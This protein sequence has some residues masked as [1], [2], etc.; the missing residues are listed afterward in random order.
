MGE[1]RGRQVWPA[2]CEILADERQ[3]I[4]VHDDRR[5]GSGLLCDRV[6]KGLVE[7]AVPFPR[8]V[9]DPVE[10][11]AARMVE[12]AVVQEPQR[13]VRDHLGGCPPDLGRD[14]NHA[15]LQRVLSGRHCAARSVEPIRLGAGRGDPER[16]PARDHRVFGERAAQARCH[17]ARCRSKLEGS[18]GAAHERERSPVRDDDEAE[19]GHETLSPARRRATSSTSRA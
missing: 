13:A 15:Q 12:Q 7:L 3:V 18:P 10:T 8:L 6:S 5:P 9:P 2:L 19:P 11:R 17:A 1:E 14:G 4:V 16:S